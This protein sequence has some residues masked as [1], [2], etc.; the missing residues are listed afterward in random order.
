[1]KI[2]SPS[3]YSLRDSRTPVLVSAL[4]VAANLGLNLALIRVLG[5][6]GLAVGTAVAAVLNAGA[7]LWL[8]RNRLGGL[9]GGRIAVAFFKISVASL[10]MGAAAWYAS[11][12]LEAALPGDDVIMKAVR[13]SASIAAG[14]AVLLASARLLRIA[15][16]D[17]ALNRVLRR[18]VPSR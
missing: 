7:L 15:E 2:A 10:L 12:S 8:L 11:Q 1:V 18:V 3:F 17:E 16:F 6:K 13:V 4:S 14:I 5:Y 9:E